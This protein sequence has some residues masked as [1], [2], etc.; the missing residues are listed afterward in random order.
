MFFVGIG[1]V[2][3]GYQG[4]F[5]CYPLPIKIEKQIVI[6]TQF[7]ICLNVCDFNKP[8]SEV[9]INSQNG[10]PEFTL[11]KVLKA[12]AENNLQTFSE[13]SDEKEQAKIKSSFELYRSILQGVNDPV[14]VRRFD[15]GVLHY[16]VL[17]VENKKFP[18]VPLILRKKGSVFRQS[19]GSLVHPICQNISTLSRA[20]KNKPEKFAPTLEPKFNAEVPILPLF[21]EVDEHK[22]NS[23]LLRFMGHKVSYPMFY[24]KP[25]EFRYSSQLK[26]L[27]LFYE[28]SFSVLKSVTMEKRDEFFA[29][30]GPSSKKK[31]K[32]F[33]ETQDLA[34]EKFA[35]FQKMQTRYRKVSYVL[36]SNDNLYIIFYQ[37]VSG[38]YKAKGLMYDMVVVEQDGEMKRVNYLIQGSLDSLLGWDKFASKFID[39]IINKPYDCP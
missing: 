13:L 6:P 3:A 36:S 25:E 30:F 23:V 9:F 35:E 10:S 32:D 8:S 26:E 31:L 15:I 34:T 18:I 24:S 17:D 1:E 16:F 38:K 29:L 37:G 11:E 22:K 19:F 12:I 4:E 21:D 39:N 20:L 33:F 5:R 28:N 14:L 7:Y 2:W 27:L